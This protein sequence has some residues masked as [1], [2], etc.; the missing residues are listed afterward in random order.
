MHVV[1]VFHPFS[2]CFSIHLSICQRS[3]MYGTRHYI[4]PTR[5][6]PIS[7]YDWWW[8]LMHEARMFG[9]SKVDKCRSV[10]ALVVQYDVIFIS[11]QFIRDIKH[12]LFTDL[13]G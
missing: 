13:D 5:N 3:V 9:F 1:R 10:V 8:W 11:L 4:A 2:N 6:S 12:N 7:S